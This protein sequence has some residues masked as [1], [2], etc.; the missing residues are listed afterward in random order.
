LEVAGNGS[1]KDSMS[2]LMRNH[3]NGS[4]WLK[5]N[6]NPFVAHIG[7]G[8]HG[9]PVDVTVR[10]PSGKI[11]KQKFDLRTMTE[12]RASSAKD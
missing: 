12:I 7:L 2:N 8:Q 3:G 9:D 1:V 4:A 5:V 10:F 11:V 6:Q